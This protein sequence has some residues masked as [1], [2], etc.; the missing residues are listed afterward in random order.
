M[1]IREIPSAR[2]FF[3]DEDIPEIQRDIAGIL[4]SGRLILGPYTKDFEQS[5][6][7]YTGVKHA[8]AVSSCTAALEIVLRFF[9]ISGKEVIVPT[10][11]FVATANAVIYAGGKPVLADLN[12]N[13]LCLDPADVERRV[14]S[15]TS[16]IVA[17]HIAG[18]IS[19]DIERLA[20]ICKNKG[21]FLI[22]DAAH[23]A[24]AVLNGKKAGAIGDAGCF[25]FYPTK[26]MTTCTGG[27]ITTNIDGLAEYA[28]SLRHHG[29]G[30]DLNNIVNFGN[31]WL[32]D[33]VRAMLGIYQLRRLE[34]N[35]NKRNSVARKY[36]QGLGKLNKVKML[37]VPDGARHSYYKYP[38]ILTADI[39][40]TE[41]LD[42]MEKKYKIAL[43]SVYD[44]P[45]HLH[46][47]YQ[48]RFKFKSGMFLNAEDILS[49]M[50][51][52]PMYSQLTDDEIEYVI[53][54]LK[55][56]IST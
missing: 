20:D 6:R 18:L 14:T 5:F 55:N 12:P 41:L 40:K 46:P 25:S 51:C 49:R 44:P 3:H 34:E 27:M 9:K 48:K 28:A 19:P 33:E 1:N 52:L 32:M 29:V 35:I 56:E 43:G 13:T 53:Q 26:V 37:P 24:G 23:A 47:A 21:L 39:D 30:R 22:E 45:V 50:V 4:K 2:P 11:T 16:G 38:A 7:E 36:E 17:V 42:K 10:N 8:I 15:R 31:D 54:A